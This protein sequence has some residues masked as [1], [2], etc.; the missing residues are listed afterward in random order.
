M[1]QEF[2]DFLWVVVVGILIFIWVNSCIYGDYFFSLYN[3]KLFPDV[4]FS[5]LSL[6]LSYGALKWYCH[7]L[8]ANNVNN[9]LLFFYERIYIPLIICFLPF[10]YSFKGM[11][12]LA[13]ISTHNFIIPILL[14]IILGDP[15]G[16]VNE[17]II[18]RRFFNVNNG[19]A[20]SH[21]VNRQLKSR[22]DIF[23]MGFFYNLIVF[24]PILIFK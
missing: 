23:I 13:N 20:I 1:K 9:I 19:E 18:N 14:I 7:V 17:Y 16:Y 12:V 11:A 10:I 6:L 15:Y 8:K 4:L 21:I 22:I 24:I 3:E 5:I 2:F